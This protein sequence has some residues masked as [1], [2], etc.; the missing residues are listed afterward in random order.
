[1]P[2]T[3]N[4]KLAR[5]KV[6][7]EVMTGRM[8]NPNDLNCVDCGHKGNDRRHEYDHHLGY[9]VSHHL[10]V[11]AVCTIC[12]HKRDCPKANQTHCIHGHLF[13]S[14]NTIIKSNGMRQCRECRKAFDKKRGRDAAFWRAYRA[15]RRSRYGP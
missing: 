8:T 3:D 6:N 5:Y 2:P 13:D 15:K 7:L 4:K 12:H 14:A 10:D 9:D 11:E 1:M